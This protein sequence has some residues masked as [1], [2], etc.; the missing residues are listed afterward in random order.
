[1][2]TLAEVRIAVEAQKK[3]W[4][5]SPISVSDFD[6]V[7]ENGEAILRGL[8]EQDFLEE[9]DV[10]D[11]FESDCADIICEAE[12]LRSDCLADTLQAMNLN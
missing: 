11:K 8:V 1:M 4:L 2:K 3:K 7:F 10:V 6:A 5:E 12:M 9:N